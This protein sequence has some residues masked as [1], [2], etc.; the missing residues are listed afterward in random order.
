MIIPTEDL[1]DFM[2][3]GSRAISQW[4]GRSPDS[5]FLVKDKKCVYFMGGALQIAAGGSEVANIRRKMSSL[6]FMVRG[7]KIVMN[8]WEDLSLWI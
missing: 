4:W 7:S 1:S 8:W 3:R 2:V 5:G 6:W